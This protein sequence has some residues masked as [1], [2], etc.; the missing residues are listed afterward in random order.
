MQDSA[1]QLTGFSRY[2]EKVFAFSAL[3]AQVRDTRRAPRIPTAVVWRALFALFLFRLPSFHQLEAEL[4][5]PA[6]CAA[7]GAAG[8][9]SEDTLRYV[10]SRLVPATLE[11]LLVRTTQRL[12]RNKAFVEGQVAGRLVAALDGI[13]FIAS[14]SR[15]CPRCLRRT[16][17]VQGQVLTEYYHRAVLCQ[18]VGVRPRVILGLEL[19]APG[20][21]EVGA[22]GRLLTKLHR[23]YRRFF[24]VLTLDALYAQ[25]PVLALAARYGWA[26]VITLKQ[27][28]RS[29]WQ[30]AQG[31]F[32]ARPPD[33]VV[34]TAGYTLRL[35][36]EA[37]LPFPLDWPT[38]VR[39]VRSE[40]Q[41]TVVRRVGRECRPAT[42][43]Q[44]WVWVSTLTPGQV[45][46]VT[47]R[48]IGHLRWQEENSGFNDLTQHWGLKHCFLHT[49][50]GLLAVLLTL[51]L[52]FNLFAAFVCR[53][54][55]LCR[56]RRWTGLAI[57]RQLYRSLFLAP[58]PALD[59]S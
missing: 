57:A 43:A 49:P 7:V 24:D 11:A 39:V 41:H 22:A 45:R 28:S 9:F 35:W 33:Q 10:G 42:V 23:Q 53:H 44:T 6:F 25:G 13:E 47:V 17:T 19:L 1:V 12:K 52:A 20:E 36:D 27:A 34:E 15:C 30:D 14:R 31:L 50:T 16:V 48:N 2:L 51:V 29:L 32:A 56:R 3:V 46:A 26:L 37:G 59:S 55:P 5:Q 18:L 38:P 21:D 8:P 58:P 4:Q 40:E 54:S